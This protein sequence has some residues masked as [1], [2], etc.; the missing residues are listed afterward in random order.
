MVARGDLGVELNPEEVPP[1]QKRIVE[2]HAPFGQAGGGGDADARIDD[3]KPGAD[4]AEVSDVA[5]A[6]YDGADAVMLSAET[7]AGAWP[8]EA[9]TIM[10]RIATQVEAIPAMPRASTS[11]RP[12]RSHHR[13]RAGQAC[14]EIAETVPISGSSCSPGRDRPRAASRANGRACRCWC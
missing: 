3:R 12:A 1:L 7:A 13:R 11:P 5:N 8:V 6:V 14:A 9:V 10:H 2:S 4:R